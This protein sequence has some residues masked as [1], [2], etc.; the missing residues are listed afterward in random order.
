MRRH[1]QAHYADL[2]RDYC[3]QAGTLSLI[4]AYYRDRAVESQ[5]HTLTEIER[6]ACRNLRSLFEA[7]A[8]PGARNSESPHLPTR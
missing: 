5:R 4:R 7:L 2:L 6:D 3:R 1:P 8:P